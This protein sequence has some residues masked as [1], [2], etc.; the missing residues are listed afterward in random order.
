MS[1]AVKIVTTNTNELCTEFGEKLFIGP[2]PEGW[3]EEIGDP[4]F[5]RRPMVCGYCGIRPTLKIASGVA[6]C[7]RC[8]N[9]RKLD[10]PAAYHWLKVST[11]FMSNID[12]YDWTTFFPKTL[13]FSGDESMKDVGTMFKTAQEV[14]KR[15]FAQVEE[16]DGTKYAIEVCNKVLAPFNM[17]LALHPVTD[18]EIEYD[19]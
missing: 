1:T 5:P 14:Q 2:L 9:W 13:G 15:T 10:G 17:K 6:E 12:M 18:K 11:L 16:H 4:R 7:P 3:Y 8:W 19:A